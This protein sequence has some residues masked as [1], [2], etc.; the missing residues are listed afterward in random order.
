MLAAWLKSLGSEVE[1][2]TLDLNAEE[3][4]DSTVEKA[5]ELAAR[6]LTGQQS[7]LETKRGTY[8]ETP[9]GQRRLEFELS[10]SRR[11]SWCHPGDEHS[12]QSS[13]SC[14]VFTAGSSQD[15]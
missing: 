15:E 1:S 10:S 12:T 11:S 5:E 9:G 14:V 8:E 3:M 2:D 4:G 6:E 7:Q 13:F